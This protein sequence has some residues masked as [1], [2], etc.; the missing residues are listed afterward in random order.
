MLAL[1]YAIRTFSNLG[2][3]SVFA[4]PRLAEEISGAETAVICTVLMLIPCISLITLLVINQK[5]NA[6]FARHKIPVGLMGADL[7]A[8]E[9]KVK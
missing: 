1:H 5:A 3:G 8:I 6:F 7:K 9:R 4:P 2:I